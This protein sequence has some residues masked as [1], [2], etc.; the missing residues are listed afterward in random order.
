VDTLSAR[1][2]SRPPARVR[3]GESTL[4]MCG[5]PAS[6]VADRRDDFPPYDE[7]PVDA[8][9]SGICGRLTDSVSSTAPTVPDRCARV[10]AES[11]P[12]DQGSGPTTY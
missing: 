12:P 4:A 10:L 9:D 2:V 1:L 5:V 7:D 6:G 8:N 11:R 3:P